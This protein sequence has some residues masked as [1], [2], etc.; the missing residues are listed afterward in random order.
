MDAEQIKADLDS[1]RKR[2]AVLKR[3]GGLKGMAAMVTGSGVPRQARAVLSEIFSSDRDYLGL[4]LVQPK[5]GEVGSWFENHTAEDWRRDIQPHTRL[6]RP[7]Y[8]R[9]I[10]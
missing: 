8:V 10:R 5:H 7:H 4:H 9:A 2:G 6:G 1:K 3:I